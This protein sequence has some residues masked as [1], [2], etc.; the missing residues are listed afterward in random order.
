MNPHLAYI[1]HTDFD[2]DHSQ[3]TTSHKYS[4]YMVGVYVFSNL[5]AK[6]YNLQYNIQAAKILIHTHRI[7]IGFLV[8]NEL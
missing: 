5:R 3:S 2:L 1:G 7:H 6:V 8:Q 4:L